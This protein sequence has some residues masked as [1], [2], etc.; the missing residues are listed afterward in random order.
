MQG[1]DI[2]SFFFNVITWD[3]VAW[4][5]GCPSY[6]C[7]ISKSCQKNLWQPLLQTR[8]MVLAVSFLREK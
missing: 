6:F 3:S 8:Q 5:R 4:G 1:I 2:I 7:L